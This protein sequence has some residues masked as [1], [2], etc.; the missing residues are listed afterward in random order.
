MTEQQR[1]HVFYDGGCPICRREIAHYRRLDRDGAVVWHDL[2]QEPEAAT[3]HGIDP[4]AAM[5]VFHVVDS[6][7]RIRTGVEGFIVVWRQLPGWHLLAKLVRVFRLTRP[8]E[9]AYRWYAPRRLRR[10]E[11]CARRPSQGHG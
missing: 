3:T 10:R 9:A 11:R 6:D 4:A 1:P 8:L 7:A 5:A 2:S